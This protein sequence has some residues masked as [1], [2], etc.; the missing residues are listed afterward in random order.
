MLACFSYNSVEIQGTLESFSISFLPF[1][2]IKSQSVTI[3]VCVSLPGAVSGE[4]CLPY[5]QLD[6]Q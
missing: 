1:F 2:F 4:V 5:F 3:V 6:R